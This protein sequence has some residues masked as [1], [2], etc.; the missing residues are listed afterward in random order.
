MVKHRR[1]ASARA[2]CA[3][4]TRRSQHS[5]EKK[6]LRYLP[7]Q[8][9][10]LYIEYFPMQSIHSDS[11]F[12]RLSAIFTVYSQMYIVCVCV[13]IFLLDAVYAQSVFT[14]FNTRRRMDGNRWLEGAYCKTKKS[15]GM[16]KSTYFRYDIIVVVRV[17]M[18][19]CRFLLF[20]APHRSADPGEQ[21]KAEHIPR[22]TGNASEL[23][24]SKYTQ[25]SVYSYSS[26]LLC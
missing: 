1:R 10:Y 11:D 4:C 6:S 26:S 24:S 14:A 15:N 9:I 20:T 17:H 7:I 25:I 19:V 22:A 18:Y 12:C 3:V 21:Q 23:R 2:P 13:C 16:N 8:Y 5:R